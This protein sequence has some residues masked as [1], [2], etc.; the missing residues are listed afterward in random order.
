MASRVGWPGF[1]DAAG[2]TQRR[3]GGRRLLDRRRCAA[4]DGAPV[5]PY[6]WRKSWC[7][8]RRVVGDYNYYFDLSALLHSLT[9]ANQWRI[10]VLVDEAHNLVDGP[11]DVHGHAWRKP[12]GGPAPHRDQR[13]SRNRWAPV[14]V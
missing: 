9:V 1:Y 7:L 5:C 2:R 12:A 3:A 8:E 6:Y 4:C 11:Q 13:S 10:G 14:R